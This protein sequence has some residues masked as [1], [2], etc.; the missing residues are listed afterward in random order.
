MRNIAKT[1]IKTSRLI[2]P[3]LV[4]RFA[5]LPLKPTMARL[6]L[7]NTPRFFFSG[8]SHENIIKGSYEGPGFYMEQLLTG[9]L[10]LYSYYIE[11]GS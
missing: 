4:G 7:T 8:K 1:A 6:N 5:S 2:A 11:S 10:S 3:L 9:C